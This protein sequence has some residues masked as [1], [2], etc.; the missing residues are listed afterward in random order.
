[1][2]D[3]FKN[4]SYV[5][6][7]TLTDDCETVLEA[8]AYIAMGSCELAIMYVDSWVFRTYRIA[9]VEA[10]GSLSTR[11]FSD[12]DCLVS[13][14]ETQLDII[15]PMKDT[16]VDQGFIGSNSCDENNFRWSCYNSSNPYISESSSSGGGGASINSSSSTT[17]STIGGSGGADFLSRHQLHQA[18]AVPSSRVLLE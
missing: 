10:N 7:E 15:Q 4:A 12:S 6:Q 9:Q 5:V 2:A 18:A 8:Y 13:L 3:A 16:I 14:N 17:S 11:Y 1:M